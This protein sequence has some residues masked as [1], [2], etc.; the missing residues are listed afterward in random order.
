M[1][2]QKMKSNKAAS[3]RYKLTATG[4]VKYKPA[5]LRHNQG[6]KAKKRKRKL[7]AKRTMFQGDVWHVEG[8][9]PYGSR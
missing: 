5:G 8:I 7:R 4:K 2:K 3:K 9:L 1:A 6:N